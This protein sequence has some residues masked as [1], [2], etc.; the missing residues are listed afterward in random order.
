ML[1]ALS[2]CVSLPKGPALDDAALRARDTYLRNHP[3]WSFKGRLAY[4]H[5]GQGGTAQVRWRQ[6]GQ[7]SE[8]TLT[9]P[10]ALGAVNIRMNPSTAQVFDASGRL[11]QSGET[12]QLLQQVLQVAMP[13]ASLMNGLRAYWPEQ[14]GT[15]FLRDAGAGPIVDGWQWRYQEWVQTPVWL[16]KKLETSREGSRL[17]LVIDQWIEVADE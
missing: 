15:A 11:L 1:L 10:M 6:A 4:S 3:D 14:A 16:P 17:R 2:A 12:E 13:A 5:Q 7:Q 8:I 9:G